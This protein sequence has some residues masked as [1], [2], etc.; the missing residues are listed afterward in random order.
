[1]DF[2]EL[3]GKKIQINKS[4]WKS[5]I[6]TP[7]WDDFLRSEWKQLNRYKKADMIGDPVMRENFITVL[8]WVWTYLQKEDHLSGGEIPKSRGI[9]SAGL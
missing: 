2:I 1:M 7:L 5:L 4:R 8:P 6:D 9:C 3:V